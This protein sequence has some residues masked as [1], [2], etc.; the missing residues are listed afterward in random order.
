[1]AYIEN[2]QLKGTWGYDAEQREDRK[3]TLAM[4]GPE[5]L[6]ELCPLMGYETGRRE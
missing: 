2:H 3:G 4:R 1:M 6:K 5:R